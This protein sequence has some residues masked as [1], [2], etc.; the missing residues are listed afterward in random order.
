M[1][2]KKLSFLL[3]VSNLSQA[4]VARRIGVSQ[5]TMSDWIN[6]RRNIPIWRKMQIAE[7]LQLPVGWLWPGDEIATPDASEVTS[8]RVALVTAR[9]W[10]TA[11]ELEGVLGSKLPIRQRAGP[12][13]PGLACNEAHVEK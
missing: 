7:L 11:P 9:D 13:T 2:D 4:S 12:R 8:A 5:M 6:G 10:L 1:K 3:K